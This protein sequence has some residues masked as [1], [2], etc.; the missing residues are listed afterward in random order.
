MIAAALVALLVKDLLSAVV[1]VGAVGIGLCMAFLLVKAP[2]LAITQLVVEI[3]GLIILVRA[4]IRRD[5]PSSGSGRWLFNTLSTIFFLAAFL[6]FASIALKD[7][8]SF[9]SQATRAASDI[10]IK[11]GC[12]KAGAYNIVS[13]IMLNFRALDTL[14]GVAVI[15]AAVIGVLAVAR[16]VG[17]NKET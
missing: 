4:T 17:H 13:A 16:K 11:E 5:I 3:L 8:P 9:A 6:G 14:G 12:A 2:D 10:Y 1:A 7:V 15:F